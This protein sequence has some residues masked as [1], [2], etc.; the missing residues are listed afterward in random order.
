MRLKQSKNPSKPLI[1]NFFWKV[2]ALLPDKEPALAGPDATGLPV[3]QEAE[4]EAG[5]WH[6]QT[7]PELQSEFK[8]SLGNSVNI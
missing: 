2:F 7:R 6:I 4:A 5:V 1:V 8:T 3:T